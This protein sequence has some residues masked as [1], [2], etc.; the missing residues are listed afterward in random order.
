MNVTVTC[1]EC[2]GLGAFPNVTEL[3]FVKFGMF[4]VPYE[5]CRQ[6]DGAGVLVIDVK[7]DSMG[8]VN[9]DVVRIGVAR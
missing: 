5:K 6:C 9:N 8:C 7:V 2:G 1:P 4:H 3:A